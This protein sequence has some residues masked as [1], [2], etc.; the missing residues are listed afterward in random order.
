MRACYIELIGVVVFPTSG[1]FHYLSKV[2]LIN[3]KAAVINIQ[4]K[5]I[6]IS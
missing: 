1:I 5:I 3:T 2:A 6:I 4:L